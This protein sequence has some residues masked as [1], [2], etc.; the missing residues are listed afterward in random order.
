MKDGEGYQK[1][2]KCVHIFAD[3]VSSQIDLQ[4]MKREERL[5]AIALYDGKSRQ[6]HGNR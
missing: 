2:T 4:I 1:L 5:H 6:S 3:I